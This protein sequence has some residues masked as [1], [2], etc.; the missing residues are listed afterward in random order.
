MI[1]LGV[2]RLCFQGRYDIVLVVINRDAASI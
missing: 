2:E 1:I